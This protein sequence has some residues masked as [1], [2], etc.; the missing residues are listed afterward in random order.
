MRRK[1]REVTN[2]EDQLAVLDECK[3]C[4]IALQDE[5]GVIHCPAE[6]WLPV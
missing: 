5:Q 6:F 3:V 4:R 2:L 1:D